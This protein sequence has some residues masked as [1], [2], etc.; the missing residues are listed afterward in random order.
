MPDW[1]LSM[2]KIRLHVI[3]PWI[4]PFDATQASNISADVLNP[5]VFRGR[6]FNCLAV[7]P[8]LSCE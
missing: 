3:E 4:Q 7:V 8:R 6:W 5:R 2:D 1:P